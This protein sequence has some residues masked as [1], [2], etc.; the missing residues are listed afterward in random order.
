M[1]KSRKLKR[2]QAVQKILAHSRLIDC[3]DHVVREGTSIDDIKFD[4][5]FT[6]LWDNYAMAGNPGYHS[7]NRLMAVTDDSLPS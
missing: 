5:E 1:R 2:L 7:A 4:I 6:I 3:R